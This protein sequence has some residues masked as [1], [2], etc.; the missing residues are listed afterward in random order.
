MQ[1]KNFYFKLSKMFF[2]SALIRFRP[3]ER[4]ISTNWWCIGLLETGNDTLEKSTQIRVQNESIS[5]RDLMILKRF[6]FFLFISFFWSVCW[7]LFKQSILFLN[8]QGCGLRWESFSSVLFFCDSPRTAM[9]THSTKIWEKVWTIFTTRSFRKLRNGKLRA[10][11]PNTNQ[12]KK[13]RQKSSL[14][15]LSFASRARVKGQGKRVRKWMLFSFSYS[16]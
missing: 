1:V 10:W 15:F 9:T 5:K 6:R 13:R 4:E 16:W 7:I 12:S 8:L 14:R 2:F 3:F 11:F